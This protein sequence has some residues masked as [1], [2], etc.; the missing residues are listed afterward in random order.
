MCVCVCVRDFRFIRKKPAS[1]LG[2][3]SF[4][5]NEPGLLDF[6]NKRNLMRTL[7]SNPDEDT[8]SALD[9]VASVSAKPRA[10]GAL[11]GSLALEPSAQKNLDQ[12]LKTDGEEDDLADCSLLKPVRNRALCAWVGVISYFDFDDKCLPRKHELHPTN[13]Y[14][15]R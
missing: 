5:K 15:A 14:C 1:L 2:S 11:T 12:R 8:R 10:I 4:L 7:L 13:V 3:L 9:L 6:E